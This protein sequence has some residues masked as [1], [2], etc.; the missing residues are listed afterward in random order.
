MRTLRSTLAV[1]LQVVIVC[2]SAF[3]QSSSVTGRVVDSQGASVANAEVTLLVSGSQRGR[4][5]R[6]LADGTFSIA[7]VAAGL[8]TLLVH[9]PGFAEWTQPITVG[10][11]P[12]TVSVTLQ[13]AGLTED[14]T[15]QGALLGTAATGKTNL[16][17]REM[18]I[19]VH[20]VPNAVLQEQGA[21]DLVSALQNVPGVYAFTNY[22]VYEGYTFRG[23]LD[24]FPSLANQLVDGVATK[25][26]ASTPSS[27]ISTASKS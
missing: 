19:T 8:H 18:P 16:P 26:T 5:V 2:S 14:V 6:S 9:A 10:S 25:E 22:G 12:S 21:N 23:F 7:G 11:E 15:V 4:T 17:L 24:L 27:P 1:V 13:V 20:T 3:A